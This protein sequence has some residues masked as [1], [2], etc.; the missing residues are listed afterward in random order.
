MLEKTVEIQ[1]AIK[2]IEESYQGKG[3]VLVRPSGTEPLIRVM[4]EGEDQDVITKDAQ[5]IADV[6]K[7]H[8]S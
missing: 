8:L 1:D 6:V 4:I 7:K 2:E 3:R 5:H